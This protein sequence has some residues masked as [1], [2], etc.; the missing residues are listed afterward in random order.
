MTVRKVTNVGRRTRGRMCTGKAR[1]SEEGAKQA[2]DARVERGAYRESINCYPCPW[3]SSWHVG[4]RNQELV[5]G[6]RRR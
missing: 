3:C 2:V 6:R 4:T 5:Q 1:Q